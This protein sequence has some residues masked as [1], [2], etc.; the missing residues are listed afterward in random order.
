VTAVA[1]VPTHRRRG[2]LTSLMRRQLDDLHERGDALAC[3]WA[4]E[5][6]IY[7][8]YGY[9]ISARAARLRARRPAARLAVAPAGDGPLRAGPAGRFVEAMR[10]VHD[11]VRVDRPGML[12]RPGPW[13]QDRLNDPE[14]ERRGAQPLQ[15]VT[16][17]DG[18]A[19]YAVRPEWDDDGPAGA[20]E[21]RELVA[22]TPAARVR[23]WAFLLD[24]DLTRTVTWR[25]APVDEPLWL[26]LTDPRA[27]SAAVVDGL[28]LRLVDVGAALSARAYASDPDVVIEVADDFCPW[29]AGRYRLADGACTRVDATP[30]LALDAG[31]LA[32][33]YLGGT[34]LLSLAAAGRVR[35]L[36]P[37]AL[38]RASAAFRG[39]VE[40]W[41]PE[42]F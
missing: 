22:A 5:G 12:D 38:A 17:D 21:V 6:A 42:T 39:A 7:A 23:L 37:G 10:S 32:T 34:T 8:R 36:T 27:V 40:P 30:D 14:S 16:V 15:A 4:S 35:E 11:R 41:C 1:V 31:S 26:A 19:L 9:G 28:W 29:N 3:L 2:L 24:Q 25:L 18:Y 20:V 13:W 33:A